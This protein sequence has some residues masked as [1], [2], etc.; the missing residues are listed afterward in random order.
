MSAIGKKE[1][2]LITCTEDEPIR[3]QRKILGIC[4]EDYLLHT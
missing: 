4:T 1:Y 3:A 2:D